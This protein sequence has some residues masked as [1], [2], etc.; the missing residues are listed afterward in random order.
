M[1]RAST[2][3]TEAASRYPRFGVEEEFFL[4]DPADGRNVPLAA[5][6]LE[7]LPASARERSKS[8]FLASQIEH[9]TGICETAA[10]AREQLLEFRAGL[11][12]ASA[13]V[14]A[15][16]AGMGTPYRAEQHPTLSPG[17]RYAEL[18][19]RHAT[20]ID[21]HQ[22]A[23]VHVHVGVPEP[24]A[25]VRG[26]RMVAAWLP[27]FKTISGNSPWW[28]AADSGFASWRTVLLRRWTTGGC[29]PAVADAEEYAARSNALVGIGGTRDEATVAWDVRLSSRYPTVELRVVDAQLTADDALLTALIARGLVSAA[30]RDPDAVPAYDPEL[31]DAA[32]WHA[33]RFGLSQ[34]VAV[35]GGEGLASVGAAIEALLGALD[36][37]ADDLAV[38]ERGLQRVLEEGTGAE[39]QRAAAG[40]GGWDALR[41]YLEDS[42]AAS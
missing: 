3:G 21:E 10:D 40:D 27:L 15:V 6:V 5:A 34:G 32:I 29:P 11:A 24:D 17:A 14:G 22:V 7:A 38:I 20:L 26:L 4:L 42:L 2:P 13:A 30:I 39:R 36:S 12:A 18:A 28:S 31:V 19:E 9:A 33:A 35:P 16:A 1:S 25:G 37:S 23:A 41:P 8:E